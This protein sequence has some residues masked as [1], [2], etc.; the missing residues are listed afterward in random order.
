[1]FFDYSMHFPSFGALLS[2]HLI[3]SH[4]TNTII[5]MLNVVAMMRGILLKFCCGSPISHTEAKTISFLETIILHG[6]E[7]FA[8]ITTKFEPFL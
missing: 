8:H 6:K 2:N 4:I 3:L 1:M 5:A 7:V